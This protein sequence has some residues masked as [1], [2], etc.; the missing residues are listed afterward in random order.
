MKDFVFQEGKEMEDC[1]HLELKDV[2]PWHGDV[3]DHPD[4]QYT[5]R[6]TGKEVTPFF[7]CGEGRCTNYRKEEGK[8]L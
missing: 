8:E 2:T 6:K 7:Q 4:Y 5:C 3:F 1:T